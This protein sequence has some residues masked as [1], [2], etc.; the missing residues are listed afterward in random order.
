MTELI[1]ICAKYL[2]AAIPLIL[3][4]VFWQISNAQ[5]RVLLLRGLLVCILAVVLAKG[6]GAL[7]NEPRPFVVQHIAPL[8][9]HEADNGFPPTTRC[10]VLPARSP[11]SVLP[12]AIGPAF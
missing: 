8:I 10:S 6:G 12:R 2:F 1:I 4:Y 9:P 3:I 7:Y 11:G 5:R